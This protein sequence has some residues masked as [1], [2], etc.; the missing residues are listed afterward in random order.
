MDEEIW[1]WEI[2]EEIRDPKGFIDKRKSRI[3]AK[4]CIYV[5]RQPD[6]L[7]AQI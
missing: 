2:L 1:E 3:L 4:L 6:V 5:I 7:G